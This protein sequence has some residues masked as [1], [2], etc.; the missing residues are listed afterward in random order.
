MKYIWSLSCGKRGISVGFGIK[1]D[2]S[3]N[4]VKGLL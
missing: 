2:A 4:I 3:K 1:D